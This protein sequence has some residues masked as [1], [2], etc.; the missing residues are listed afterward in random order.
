M[1]LSMPWR[2]S[3]DRY[4]ELENNIRASPGHAAEAGDADPADI[5]T[6][7]SQPRPE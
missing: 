4:G 2:G 7:V 6:E 5:F 1:P 3:R